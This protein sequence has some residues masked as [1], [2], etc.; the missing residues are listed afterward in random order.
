[1]TSGERSNRRRGLTLVEIMVAI[2][3]I[4]VSLMMVLA[5]IPAGIHSAQRAENVQSAAAWSRQLIEDAPVPEEFPIAPDIAEEQFEMKIGRTN[6]RAVRR[7]STMPGEH[8][9]YRID[10][11]TTWDEAQQPVKLSLVKYNPAGPEP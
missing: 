10:V 8:F 5:L 11:E 9:V 7:L 6:Y 4:A 3:L 1:M 2:G